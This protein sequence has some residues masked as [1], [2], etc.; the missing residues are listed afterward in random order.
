MP[1]TYMRAPLGDF[2][3]NQY[4]HALRENYLFMYWLCR[5]FIAVLGLSLVAAK[6]GYS[7]VAVHGFP[8]AV[9][10]LLAEHGL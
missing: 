10:S 9:V 5:V 4:S 3:N 2:K 8:I 1:E 6:R 7:L